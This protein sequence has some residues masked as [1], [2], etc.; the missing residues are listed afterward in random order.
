M[1][2]EVGEEPQDTLAKILLWIELAYK[3]SIGEGIL[4]TDTL[5]SVAVSSSVSSNTTSYS[6][7][8]ARFFGAATAPLGSDTLNFLLTRDSRCTSL[9]ISRR[10]IGTVLHLIQDSFARG[11]VKRTLKNPA[12]LMPGSVDVFKTGKYGKYGDIENFH[13]YRGQNEAVHSQYDTFDDS[14]FNYTNL[15]TF[16]ELRG[17]RDAIDYSIK[18]L[19]F[20]STNTPY[21]SAG[22]PKDMFQNKIFKLS[23]AATASN[24]N[25]D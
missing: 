5:A 4:R 25:V 19:D 2:S 20:W 8:L 11:H 14:R 9:D 17:A 23:A 22:G 21:S 15:S 18:L 10:A 1:A 3:L 13:C 24:S 7:S 16:N 6:Y 12:D